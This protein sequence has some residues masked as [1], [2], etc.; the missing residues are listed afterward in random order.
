MG[1]PKPKGA[2]RPGGSG[3][4]GIFDEL[5]QK[6]SE[7]SADG[8]PAT[9]GT[10]QQFKITLYRN[11]F[12]V[13]DGPLRDPST[14][15]NQAFMARLMEGRVPDEITRQVGGRLDA[16]DV[17]LADK[18]SED[19]VAPPPP[20]YVAFSGTGSTLRGLSRNTEGLV[21]SAEVLSDVEIPA[22]DSVP[23]TL[24]IQVRTP[25]GKRL[26]IK[27]NPSATIYQLAAMIVQELGGSVTNF[28]LSAGY[29]PTVL[30]DGTVSVSGANL[31]KDVVTMT[32]V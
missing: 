20:A 14:P 26:K 7:S 23:G 1:P 11:G 24:T 4:A 22:P 30:K 3:A 10:T 9:D 5:V 8:P 19:Y 27:I 17:Q 31:A 21:F 16:M 13:N 15:E 12:T 2:P 28:S 25:S 32:N 29:P 6:A 18:R